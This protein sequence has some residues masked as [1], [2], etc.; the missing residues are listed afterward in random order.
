MG[1]NDAWG[2]GQAMHHLW[3]EALSPLYD[4]VDTLKSDTTTALRTASKFTA[5]RIYA[6]GKN[7]VVEGNFLDATS[8][9]LVSA[10][11]KLVSKQKLSQNHGRALFENLP[12]GKYIAVIRSRN[13]AQTSLVQVK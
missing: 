13:A 2:G 6:Q 10:T 1:T 8:V 7:I 11:G 12:A 3:A 9:S 4:A 5:P